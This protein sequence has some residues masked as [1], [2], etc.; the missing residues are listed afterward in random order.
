[1][2]FFGVHASRSAAAS[3]THGVAASADQAVVTSGESGAGKTET[4]KLVLKHLLSE[5]EDGSGSSSEPAARRV[6]VASASAMPAMQARLL[7][8]SRFR[9]FLMLLRGDHLQICCR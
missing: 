6:S 7:Q 2:A 9:K 4:F 8:S 5:T 3:G 1:L